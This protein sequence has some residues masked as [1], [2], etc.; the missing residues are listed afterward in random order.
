MFFAVSLKRRVRIQ[1][2]L[3]RTFISREDDVQLFT[4]RRSIRLPCA[5]IIRLHSIYSEQDSS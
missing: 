5:T 1:Q 2:R 4:Y 3:E